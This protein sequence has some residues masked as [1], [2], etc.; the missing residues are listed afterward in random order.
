MLRSK[1][2]GPSK[3]GALDVNPCGACPGPQPH[4]GAALEEEEL[5]RAGR[6]S[7]RWFGW[8]RTRPNL[9]AE[10]DP[11]PVTCSTSP[12]GTGEAL[13]VLAG[14][15]PADHGLPVLG[16]LHRPV[17]QRPIRVFG[18]DGDTRVAVPGFPRPQMDGLMD[19][20]PKLAASAVSRWPRTK[21][22]RGRKDQMLC[23]AAQD[24]EGEDRLV[25]LLALSAARGPPG[26]EGQ[27][28]P[29]ADEAGPNIAELSRPGTN[30]DA[31]QPNLHPVEVGRPTIRLIGGPA[32]STSPKEGHPDRTWPEGA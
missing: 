8:T 9:Q 16:R 30:G 4:R 13:Q 1:M 25:F 7:S 14:R 23:W 18:G 12:A 22:G 5:S 24:G 10:A 21:T 26:T 29:R 15:P 11:G 19:E 31:F 3:A 2:A 6:Q 27:S 20:F 32:R 28:R 17:R